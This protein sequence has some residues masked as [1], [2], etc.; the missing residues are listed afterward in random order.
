MAPPLKAVCQKAA[1]VMGQIP[2]HAGIGSP[3]GA[4]VYRM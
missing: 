2:S 4:A 1:Q 3:G